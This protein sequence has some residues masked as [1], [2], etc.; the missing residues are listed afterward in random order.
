MQKRELVAVTSRSFSKHPG[1]RQLLRE[2]FT[3]VKFNESGEKLTGQSLIEFLSGAKR[4]IIGLEIID[5]SLLKKLPDLRAICKVGTGIDKVDLEVIKRYKVAFAHT[6]GVNKRSVSEL[7]LGLIFTLT[8][9]LPKV[10]YT[11]KQG[12]WHQPKGSLLSDK[13]IG[14][15]GFGAIGQDLAK[16]L[17][18]FDCRCL[19]YDIQVHANLLPHVSQVKLSDL[20]NE[21][22]IISLHIPM[23]DENYHFLDSLEFVKMKKGCIL[24]NTARGGLVNEDDL[25]DALVNGQLAAAAFDVF[26]NEP[27]VPKKLLA[28][29]NFFATSHI[30]GS[31]EEAIKAM[32]QLAI[33]KLGELPIN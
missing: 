27:I 3:H 22:D 14:I 24:I 20:L 29:E 5:E 8:R 23:T 26:E 25:Y 6:P 12:E 32:G 13:T 31:T 4:A 33:K 15:I 10:Y 30:A 2:R 19:I 18:I 28:L 17:G 7:V 1:L 16:L 11:L 9:H 21:S